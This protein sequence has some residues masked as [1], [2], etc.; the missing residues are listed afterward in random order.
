M[1][2]VAIRIIGFKVMLY[3]YEMMHEKWENTDERS[4]NRQFIATRFDFI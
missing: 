3:W 1:K 2:S 4:T